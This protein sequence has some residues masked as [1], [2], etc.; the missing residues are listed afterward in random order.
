MRGL[1]QVATCPSWAE[2]NKRTGAREREG[3]E[4]EGDRARGREMAEVRW[5]CQMSTNKRLCILLW[6]DTS[7]GDMERCNTEVRKK[8]RERER[9]REKEERGE[10]FDPLPLPLLYHSFT[11]PFSISFTIISLSL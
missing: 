3:I 5:R 4:T 9:E 8:R 10:A 11:P 1:L 2:R 7:E 6:I